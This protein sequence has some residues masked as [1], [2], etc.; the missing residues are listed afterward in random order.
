MRATLLNSNRTSLLQKVPTQTA[1]RMTKI[2]DLV[3]RAI[4]ELRNDLKRSV[5]K[6]PVK[7]HSD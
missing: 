6:S 2:R 3:G 7:R 1:I 4:G 5:S